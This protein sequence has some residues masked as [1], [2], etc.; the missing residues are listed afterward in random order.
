MTLE[1]GR[2]VAIVVNGVE[3]ARG[4]VAQ[5]DNY[6]EPNEQWTWVTYTLSGETRTDVWSTSN[7]VR[8]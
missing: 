2:R 7:L 5:G 1:R 4:R 8:C 6:P 3:V